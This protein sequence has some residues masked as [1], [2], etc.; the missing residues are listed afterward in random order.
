MILKADS[1]L[2]KF[3]FPGAV[4]ELAITSTGGNISTVT[5]PGRTFVGINT[6]TVIRYQQSGSSLEYYNRV[7]ECCSRCIIVEISAISS[8]SGV[9]NGALP[10][11]DIQVNGFLGRTNVRGSGTLFAPLS[12]QILLV[13]IFLV[14]S[15]FLSIN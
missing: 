2:S 5:S 4:S 12:E 1:I 15:L 14:L 13:L 11:S 6:D 9:F 10:T 7:S 8:V 3:N